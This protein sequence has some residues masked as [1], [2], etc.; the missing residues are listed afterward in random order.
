MDQALPTYLGRSR[1][2]DTRE[3]AFRQSTTPH[4]QYRPD[5]DGLRAVAVLAVVIFHAAPGFLPGGFAGVDVFFVISG[6]LISGIIMRGLLRDDFS[7]L[8]FYV[9]RV[10]RIFPALTVVLICVW[11]CGWLLLLPNEHRQLGTHVAAGAGFALNLLQYAH[12]DRYFGA[13]EAAPLMHLWSLGVEEQFY[14]AWPLLLLA[15]WKYCRG[16]FIKV[17]LMLIVVAAAVSFAINTAVVF[18]QPLAA[19]YLPSSRLWELAMGGALAH[20]QLFSS[21]E[22]SRLRAASPATVLSKLKLYGPH[23]QGIFGAALLLAS[24]AGLDSTM[25]FPGWWALAPSLG[26]L[27]LISAGPQG[28]FNRCVL[29]RRPMVFIGV[30]SFPLYLWHWPLLAFADIFGRRDIAPGTIAVLVAAAF[31]L[32][33]ATYRF[34]EVPLRGSSQ[35]MRVAGVLC[36]AMLVC[37]GIGYLTSTQ[38]IHAR[39]Q[40]Y[41][42]DRFTQGTT[43]DWL[44][45]SNSAWTRYV[46][47]F[48]MLGNASQRVLFIG[49]SNMQ[50]Y[51][52]RIEK[53]LSD[54]P[55]NTRGAV[56]AVRAG[57]ALPLE[58]VE[59]DRVACGELL[60]D[61]LEYAQDPSVDTIVIAASWYR[62]FMAF[63]G[64]E[65]FGE[66]GR[67]FKPGYEAALQSLERTIAGL[68]GQGKRVYVVLHIPIGH[69]FDP[70]HMIRRS[71]LPPGFSVVVPAPA[72]AEI[73]KAVEPIV[74]RIERLARRAGA[75]IID[76]MESLCDRTTCP[77]VSSQGEPIY[78]DFAHLRPSYVREHVRFLDFAVLDAVASHVP[79]M[80][81]ASRAMWLDQ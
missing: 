30:I 51:Y 14:L 12:T 80:D 73:A 72:R 57:C 56:F 69:S 31:I 76:P 8:D 65:H 27:A 1:T 28:W 42:I 17:Q 47:K 29:S 40:S 13:V 11:A 19:F 37:G 63:G 32:A 25:A 9:R 50:Q 62:H 3:A 34:I 36:T 10:N 49:D 68:V 59:L 67:P 54:R 35:R 2:A 48:L 81:G 20:A 41:G 43:E 55:N 6:F 61:A 26:A 46:D 39:S 70:H 5:I 15:T 52:P 58:M 79:P 64:L 75:S 44:P 21:G 4:L 53:L 66:A 24:F 78:R 23:A 45:N 16:R 38:R 18:A 60:R 77:A 33:W 7:C 71:L 22:S 74:S